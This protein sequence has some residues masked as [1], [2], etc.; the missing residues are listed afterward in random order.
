MIQ[1]EDNFV[2][3]ETPTP[4]YVESNQVNNKSEKVF[5]TQF[6]PNQVRSK[7]EG[8]A[9]ISEA[10]AL[11]NTGKSTSKSSSSKSSNS[12]LQKPPEPPQQLS[13]LPYVSRILICV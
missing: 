1:N 6:I 8:N 11:Y 12:M 2:V 10:P 9:T 13:A 4:K 7:Y 5:G 3:V